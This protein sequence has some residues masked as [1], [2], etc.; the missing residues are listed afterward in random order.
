[1]A[2]YDHGRVLPFVAGSAIAQ[3]AAAQMPIASSRNEVVIPAASSGQDMI[4]LTI[5]TQAT[6]GLEVSILI[7]GVGKARAAA[8]VGAGALVA[9]ASTN[10]HLGPVLA[11]GALASFGAS[12]GLQPA[13]YAVGRSLVAAAAGEYF[14]VLVQPRQVI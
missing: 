5:A 7:D 12:A 8:S 14:A 3:G 1:M 11:S 9:P 4:G 13:R 6:Y 2:H 10:G